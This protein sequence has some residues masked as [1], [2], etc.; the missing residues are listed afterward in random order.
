MIESSSLLA[1]VK[2]TFLDIHYT[3]SQLQMR[4]INIPTVAFSQVKTA[5]VNR[6]CI[7]GSKLFVKAPPPVSSLGVPSS[8]QCAWHAS[9]MHQ[10]FQMTSEGQV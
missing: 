5:D 4:A 9:Q 8:Q 2:R 7:C 3:S 10:R 6:K 1:T